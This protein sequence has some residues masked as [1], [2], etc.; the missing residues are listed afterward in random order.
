M[1]GYQLIEPDRFLSELLSAEVSDDT[2][3]TMMSWLIHLLKN[4]D[5]LKVMPIEIDIVSV[6]YYGRYPCIGIH[7][8]DKT[9]PDVRNVVL[10]KLEN[11]YKENSFRSFYD[12]IAN[13]SN[14]IA[15]NISDY[16]AKDISNF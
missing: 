8:L 7:Y 10:Q 16:I 3:I 14:V 2:I 15:K 4:D 1:K 5:Q 6:N 13:N 11:Y 12:Y 9:T